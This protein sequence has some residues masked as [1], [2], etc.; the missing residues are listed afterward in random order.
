M[1]RDNHKRRN[2][3]GFNLCSAFWGPLKKGKMT[4]FLI[5]CLA[6]LGF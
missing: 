4:E 6:F 5:F 1:A 3:E 2:T